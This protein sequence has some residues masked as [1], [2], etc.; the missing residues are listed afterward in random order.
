[1]DTMWDDI[2]VI[3]D[4]AGIDR[5][6]AALTA[7]ETELL[8][9]GIPAS[10][11]RFDLAWHDWLNLR[12]LVEVSGVIAHAAKA[13]ENSRGAHF[14][15]DFPAPGDFASSRFTVARQQSGVLT[16]TEEPVR[17]THVRP[18]ETLLTGRAAE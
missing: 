14:R 11:R 13:R 2:G 5:G 8:A 4:A 15:A 12:S 1:M 17:F 3:R 18:G 6:I 9:T 7:I 16:I 10:D